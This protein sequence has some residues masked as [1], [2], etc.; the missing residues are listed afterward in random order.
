MTE[1][2]VRGVRAEPPRIPLLVINSGDRG[3][4]Q[5][6]YQAYNLARTRYPVED[7]TREQFGCN[8]DRTVSSAT[9]KLGSITLI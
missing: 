9:F 5:L 2:E 3:E 4:N 1:L 7:N 6:A 8:A